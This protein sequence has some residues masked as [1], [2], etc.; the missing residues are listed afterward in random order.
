VL[1][2]VIALRYVALQ[3]VLQNKEQTKW[4]ESERQGAAESRAN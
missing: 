3:F 4:F 2:F 1:A